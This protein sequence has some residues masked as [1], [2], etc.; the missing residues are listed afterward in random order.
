MRNKPSEPKE[1]DHLKSS[2]NG[3]GVFNTTADN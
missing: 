1:E 3:A 2:I